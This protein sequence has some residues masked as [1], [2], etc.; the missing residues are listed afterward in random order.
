M[1]SLA[2]DVTP[3]E[4]GND[5]SLNISETDNALDLDLAKTVAPYFKVSSKRAD[6][7][8]GLVRKSVAQW[9]SVAKKYGVSKS[10]CDEMA[11]AFNAS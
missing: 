4:T 10:S 8:V 1:L 6:A 2:Y 11:G 3:V 7:I 9:R 5:L